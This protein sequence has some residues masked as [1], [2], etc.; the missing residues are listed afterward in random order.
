ML[1]LDR[2]Q[3]QIRAA[4]ERDGRVNRQMIRNLAVK[5]IA[6]KYP[7]FTGKDRKHLVN[8]AYKRLKELF[9]NH[10]KKEMP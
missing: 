5:H 10:I 2:E 9:D 1:N 4:I 6:K 3:Q 7:M 8:R